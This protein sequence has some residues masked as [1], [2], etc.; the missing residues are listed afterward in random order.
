MWWKPWVLSLD[1]CAHT[2]THSHIKN[3]CK[4]SGCLWISWSS[5]GAQSLHIWTL[6]LK[7]FNCIKL[8]GQENTGDMQ[9]KLII[10]GSNS[11]YLILASNMPIQRAIFKSSLIVESQFDSEVFSASKF[12]SIFYGDFHIFLHNTLSLLTYS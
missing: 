1:T 12:T 7:C 3:W 4:V 10:L 2:H 6:V 8:L 9:C 11:A 5:L